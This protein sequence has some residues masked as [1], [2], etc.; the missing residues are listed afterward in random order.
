MCF[1]SVFTVKCWKFFRVL[2]LRCFM[3]GREDDVGGRGS[4][5]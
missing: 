1:T 5:R 2:L 4:K 3:G